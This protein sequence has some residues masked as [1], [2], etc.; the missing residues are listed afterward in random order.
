MYIFKQLQIQHTITKNEKSRQQYNSS[1]WK[2]MMTLQISE[3]V[4]LLGNVTIFQEHRHLVIEEWAFVSR[5][6]DRLF[7]AIFT[8]LN[9]VVLLAII[10]FFPKDKHLINI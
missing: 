8:C 5:I 6:I 10:L 4:R 7:F 3:Q 1:S 2:E 9:V